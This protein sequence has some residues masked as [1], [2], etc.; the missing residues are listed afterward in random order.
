MTDKTDEGLGPE[1]A[2]A[3]ATIIRGAAG[4]AAAFFEMLDLAREHCG[5]RLRG[6]TMWRQVAEE[7]SLLETSDTLEKC[8]HRD[9]VSD[10]VSP[11]KS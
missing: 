6:E 3:L 8:L 5:G 1:E 9:D 11:S 7:I 4:G 10:P 2:R